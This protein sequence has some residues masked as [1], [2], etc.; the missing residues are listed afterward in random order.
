MKNYIIILI[1][2][3]FVSSCASDYL[4]T[5]PTTSTTPEKLFEDLEGAQIVMDG[6][7]RLT[8]VAGYVSSSY[9]DQS[10]GIS[11]ITL[12]NEFMGEDMTMNEEGRGWFLDD[13]RYTV[14]QGYTNK[15]SR[16][17]GTWFFYY[18]LILN[19]N[20]ILDVIDDIISDDEVLR[21]NIKAQALSMRAYCY[22]GL[23]QT[24][25][26]AY[27]GNEDAPGVPIYTTATTIETRGNGRGTVEEVYTRINDDLTEALELF[28]KT[29]TAANK[30][31]IDYFVA[32]GFR[33]RVKMAQNEW[34][35]ALESAKIA[36]T[37][38]QMI[39]LEDLIP[40]D[41]DT[42]GRMDTVSYAREG[43]YNFNDVSNKSV[44]WGVS[45]NE[46][47]STGFMSFFSHMDSQVQSYAYYSRKCISNWLY[48]QIPK[49]DVRVLMWQPVVTYEDNRGPLFPY[50]QL[51]FKFLN[52][53]TMTGDYIYMRYEEML[54]TKAEAECRLG[55]QQEARATLKE[56]LVDRY[57]EAKKSQIDS[58]LN[59]YDGIT[60]TIDDSNGPTTP[61][62]GAVTLLDKIILERRIE[63][64]GEQNRL[65]DIKRLG[66]GFTRRFNG[67]NHFQ[68]LSTLNTD[69]ESKEFV[70]PIP[71][72]EFDANESMTSADQ[73]PL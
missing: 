37:K 12:A 2:A 55:R 36:M 33:A 19:C 25:Q 39:P 54:L 14:R 63:L 7:Y 49:Y 16:S 32:H 31:H 64:W 51:K 34:K 24:Y 11:A 57:N 45:I 10:F 42:W 28:S 52:S 71:Q 53:S 4:D 5:E 60:L 62:G 50:N 23:I 9:I 20:G 66:V 17:Y 48:N 6:I 21:A 38:G 46:E 13:Y 69:V 30:S 59:S 29:T 70:M 41:V 44:L 67:T 15:N 40:T 18:S 56:L 22:F 1:A 27:I 68:T 43:A 61:I 58:I 8:Y 35:E 73:N 65:W 72:S 26:Q 3:L 47:Q